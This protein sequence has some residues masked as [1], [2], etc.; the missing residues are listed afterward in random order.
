M[1]V[2]YLDISM[3][4]KKNNEGAVTILCS[5]QHLIACHISSHYSRLQLHSFTKIPLDYLELEKLVVFNPTRMSYHVDTF[6]NS[7]KLGHMPLFMGLY[8]PA[9]KERCINTT[10]AH[11]E[12][13]QLPISHAPHWKWEYCYLY[14]HDHSYY[15]YLCGIPRGL[16]LQFQLLALRQNWNL[17]YLTSERMALLQLYKYLF[18]QA[19]RPTQLGLHMQQRNNNIDALFSRDD[20]A[21]IITIPSHI[22]IDEH[23][24][25]SLLTSCGLFIAGES[26]A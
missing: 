7:R 3:D 14:P 21:R 24:L 26:Y 2:L 9:I 23:D 11:P 20:L 5:P 6:I 25:G 16:I 12:I 4:V 17:H 8:G 18:G 19:F 1:I 13:H 10:I 15:F 22:T